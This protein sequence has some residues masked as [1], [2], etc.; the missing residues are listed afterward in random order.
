MSLRRSGLNPLDY[1]GVEPL[2]PPALFV[3][4]RN[5]TPNDSRGFNLGSLWLNTTP[6][7]SG[8]Y[9]VWM[10]VSL[11]QGT[12]IWQQ[13]S[14]GDDELETLTGDSGGAVPPTANNIN[15]LGGTGTG[16]VGNPGTSTLTISV[17]GNVPLAFSTDAG[18]A[19]PASNTLAIDGAHGINTSGS[20]DT[21]TVAINNA[22]TLGDLANITGSPAITLTTGDATLSSGNINLTDT[23]TAATSG[24]IKFGG[25][26]FVHNFGTNNTFLGSSSGNFTLTG[27]SNN[28]VG[29]VAALN[30]TNGFFNQALG[31]DTLTVLTSGSRN[32]AGGHSTLHSITSG[33][34]NTAVGFEAGT[35]IVTGNDNIL[36]GDSCGSALTGA[37]S[38]NIF[39]DY[40]GVAGQSNQIRIGIDQTKTFIVGIRGVTTDVNDAVPVLIDSAGQLG[41]TSSSIRYKDNVEDMLDSSSPLM[42]LRPVTFTYKQHISK[43]K[44]F[45]LIAEEVANIFPELV[46]YNDEGDPETIKYQDLSVLLLNEIKKLESR[47]SKLEGK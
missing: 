39:M 38:N 11:S 21:V 14:T 5:P 40:V 10:L 28:I 33:T 41:T 7:S 46:V 8:E 24:I 43:K 6:T 12:A 13:I 9:P 19:V 42:D 27:Q 35:G 36:I 20:G 22:I 44:Q 15:I 25:L 30:I 23:N 2:T 29:H 18:T 45:G 1:L 47:I 34:S 37:D 16:V 31:D 32:F 3:D 26:R 4:N 17:D